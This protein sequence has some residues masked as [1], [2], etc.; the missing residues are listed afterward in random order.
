MKRTGPITIRHPMRIPFS[1]A[2]TL[3]L[4]TLVIYLMLTVT[5]HAEPATVSVSKRVSL[6][7]VFPDANGGFG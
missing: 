5:V 7:K 4:A 3:F 1:K 6:E 2:N